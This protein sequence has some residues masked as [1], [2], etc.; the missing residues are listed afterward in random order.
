[1][2]Y[3]VCHVPN[4]IFS[5][6]PMFDT[7][8]LVA[9]TILNKAKYNFVAMVDGNSLEDVFRLTNSINTGWWENQEVDPQFEGDGCRSTSVGDLVI[10]SNNQFYVVASSGF[11]R[12]K[13]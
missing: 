6:I 4:N 8:K 9:F 13:V 3:M 2:S 12:V 1:M 11:V 7:V 5:D 10:T